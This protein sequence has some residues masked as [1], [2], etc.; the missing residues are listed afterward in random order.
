MLP[1]LTANPQPN[2]EP[3]NLYAQH[4]PITAMQKDISSCTISE[5]NKQ[6]VTVFED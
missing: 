1:L 6:V 2:H 4:Q 3:P 5:Q